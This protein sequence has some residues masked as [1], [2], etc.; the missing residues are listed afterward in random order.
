MYINSVSQ[1]NFNAGKIVIPRNVKG[2]CLK[3]RPYLYNELVDL[4]TKNSLTS[5]FRNEG[6]EVFNPT[7]KFIEEIKNKNIKFEE[8]I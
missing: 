6:V 3:D 1:L 8:I 2:N 4:V 7:K 5:N